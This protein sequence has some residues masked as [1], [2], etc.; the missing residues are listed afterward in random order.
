MYMSNFCK[1]KKFLKD[2]DFFNWKDDYLKIDEDPNW[3][4]PGIWKMYGSKTHSY[5]WKK[6]KKKRSQVKKKLIKKNITK[7]GQ[8][9]TT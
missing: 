5:S 3:P 9:D 4:S 2:E 1:H 7:K 6:I 8:L